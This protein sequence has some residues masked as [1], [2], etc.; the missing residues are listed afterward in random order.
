[1]VKFGI[2][3]LIIPVEQHLTNLF[4]VLTSAEMSIILPKASVITGNIRGQRAGLGAKL[5]QCT[6][7]CS[8]FYLPMDM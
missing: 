4:L 3:I 5:L 6:L 2:Y 7:I 1:M 8:S